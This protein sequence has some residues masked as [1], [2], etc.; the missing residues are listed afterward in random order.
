MNYIERSITP[1]VRK[2][3]KNFKAVLITGARQTGK[4]TLLKQMF[5][6]KKYVTFDDPF[7][8]DQAVKNAD[9]FM[10]LNLP[11][12]T[13]DEVQRVPD[14]F[15]YIKM[16][17]DSRDEY[18]LYCLSGSQTFKLMYTVSESLSG[19]VSVVELAGLSLREIQG[20]SYDMPFL[21][22]LEYV[23][24]RGKTAR[25]PHNIWQIIH[26]GSYP[27]LYLSLIHI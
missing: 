9:M 4:S 18:G 24:E 27:E 12:V 25:K 1:C 23:K 6:E 14:L 11:P 20:D 19:R 17:C 8:E 13:F 16:E 7:M 2:A 5:P 22:T 10:S 15:R 21:P 26:R 3:E